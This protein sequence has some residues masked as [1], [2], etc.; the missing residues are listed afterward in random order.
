[1]AKVSWM[2]QQLKQAKREYDSWE[3]WKKEAMMREVERGSVRTKNA[4]A[5][6][7]DPR[8]DHEAGT[9][10]RKRKAS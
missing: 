10:P 4:V 6:I 3:P 7:L 9:S 5:R 8:G 1:M 2:D